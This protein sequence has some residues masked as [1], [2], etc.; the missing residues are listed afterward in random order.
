[1]LRVH[2]DYLIDERGEKKAVVV[3]FSE[4]HKIKEALEELDDIRAYDKAKSQPSE[5]LPFYEAI[6]RIRKRKPR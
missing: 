4:W 2:K 1:M 6:K 3:P 5:P